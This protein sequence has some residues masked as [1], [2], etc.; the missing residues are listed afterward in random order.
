MP[1]ANGNPKQ[2]NK[3]NYVKVKK[4]DYL[5][6]IVRFFGEGRLATAVVAGLATT[7]GTVTVTTAGENQNKDNHPRAVITTE[8]VH[9][10]DLPSKKKP[11]KSG[12]F[13]FTV[14]PMLSF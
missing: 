12:A 13:L 2:L 10:L 5:L 6:K 8:K 14:Y 9:N 7:T 11:L 3:V 4:A 1:K